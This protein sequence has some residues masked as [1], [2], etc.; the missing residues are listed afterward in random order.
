MVQNRAVRDLAGLAGITCNFRDPALLV[1]VGEAG[2]EGHFDA[3]VFEVN[4]GEEAFGEGDEDFAVCALD[5][6][7]GNGAGGAVNVEDGAERDRGG[8][9]DVD[10]FRADEVGDVD[11]VFREGG[12]FGAGNGDYEARKLFGGGDGVDAGKVEDDGALVEP[13]VDELDG[14][15]LGLRVWLS[16]GT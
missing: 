6:E 10:E 5:D 9:G 11:L 13:V 4:L 7:E 3:L 15:G 14:T 12:A 8:A 2:G 1:D 16:L